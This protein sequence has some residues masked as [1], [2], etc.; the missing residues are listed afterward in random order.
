[1]ST[2][3]HFVVNIIKVSRNFQENWIMG[4]KLRT[5]KTTFMLNFLVKTKRRYK[6][7]EKHFLFFV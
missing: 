1:M 2:S 7:K 3:H 5:I 4:T 6:I